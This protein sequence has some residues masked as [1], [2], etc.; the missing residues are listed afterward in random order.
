MKWLPYDDAARA[1]AIGNADVWLGLG[2]TPFQIVNSPWLLEHLCREAE[3]CHAAKVPMFFLGVGVNEPAVLDHPITARLLGAAERVWTRDAESAALLREGS[4][5]PWRIVAGADLAHLALERMRFSSPEPKT[6]GLVLNFE[7]AGQ[8]SAKSLTTLVEVAADA[9]NTV[10]W[11]A[12]EVRSLPGSECSIHES[13]SPE[14]RARTVLCLPNYMTAPD[15]T[16]LLAPWGTPDRLLTTRYHAA[17]IGAWAGWRTV[18]FDRSMKVAAGARQLGLPLIK[19]LANPG[20][21]F[22]ALEAVALPDPSRLQLAANLA[23]AGVEE[24]FAAV[25][26][27]TRQRRQLSL[28]VSAPTPRA[29][30][31]AVRE[32][33]SSPYQDFMHRVNRFAAAGE[34]RT[35]T[36]WSKIWEYPWLWEHGLGNVDWRGKRLVDLGS[37]ISPLPWLLAGMGAE[38]T[39]VETDPQWVPRWEALRDQLRVAVDWHLV[40]SERLPVVDASVDVLTSFSVIEH[41]RDKAATI[42]EVA[43]VLRPGGLFA[44]SFDICEPE[45]GMT[46]PTWNGR[47]LTLAEFEEILWRHPEFNAAGT[48][49]PEWNLADVPGFLRWHLRSAPHHNYVVGAAVLTRR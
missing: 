1:A 21:V 10:R 40:D 26:S 33:E 2:D 20:D 12:Q 11:L 43:R 18:V 3:L 28:P 32:L 30:L 36:N 25:A 14:A 16:A 42:A 29:R 9:G 8:F 22:R 7:D 38:V 44:M 35:F 45:Q 24:F 15:V 41:Q 23:R 48:S 47:A 37:E 19:T 46:F 34:L 39:L 13:L 49:A 6:L 5:Q 27:P 17:L 4:L 31:A